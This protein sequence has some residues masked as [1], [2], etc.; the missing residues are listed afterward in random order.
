MKRLRRSLVKL[1]ETIL[2]PAWKKSHSARYDEY[3]FA[4][5]SGLS[6]GKM[7]PSRWFVSFDKYIYDNRGFIFEIT[8]NK[9]LSG[10]HVGGEF[11][12]LINFNEVKDLE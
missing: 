5:P 4:D 11:D 1:A 9:T 6:S 8:A 7:S 10:A 3:H 2:L 12:G